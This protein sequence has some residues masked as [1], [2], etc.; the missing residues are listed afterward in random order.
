MTLAALIRKRESGKV[1][2]AIPAIAATQPRELAATVARIATVAVANPTET[3][4]ATASRWWLLHFPDRE[5]V[6]VACFPPAIH[7]EMLER[8]P[9]AIAA[10]PIHQATPE[11]AHTSCDTC[12]HVTG[13]VTGRGGCGEPVAAGLSNVVGVVVY[14]PDQGATCPAWLAI[15]PADLEVRIRDMAARWDYSGDDLTLALAGPRDDP[16]GWRRVVEADENK[17]DE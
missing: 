11:P 7:A 8:H 1:A 15:L 12:T 4:T 14:S 2:T 16:A 9:E 17:G 13:R 3:E 5:P 10:E 6:E